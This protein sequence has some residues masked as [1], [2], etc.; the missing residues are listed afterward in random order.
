MADAHYVADRVP[1]AKLVTVSSIAELRLRTARYAEI[2]G[3][4]LARLPA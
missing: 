1:G 3:G 2:V 4:F